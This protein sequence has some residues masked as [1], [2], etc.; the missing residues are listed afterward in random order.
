MIYQLLIRYVRQVSSSIDGNRAAQ[1]RRD[2]TMVRRVALLNS[3]LVVVGLQVLVF[4]I[5]TSI[6]LDLLPYKIMCLLIMSLNLPLSPMLIILFL[7]TPDPRRSLAKLQKNWELSL[8]QQRNV[9]NQ[10]RTTDAFNVKFY[11]TLSG[12]FYIL[13]NDLLSK[14]YCLTKRN[15]TAI[16][17]LAGTCRISNSCFCVLDR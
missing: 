15:F 17:T 7:I 14:S 8:H 10:W 16:P 11:K 4:V 5:L 9:C 3:Q 1:M 6:R 12:F 2:L 13:E